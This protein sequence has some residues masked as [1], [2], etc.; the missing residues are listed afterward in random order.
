MRRRGAA[1]WARVFESCDVVAT[2]TTACPAPL[3]PPGAE[4]AGTLHLPTAA[5]LV[6]FTMPANI[7]GLPAISLPVGA[8]PAPGGALPVALQLIGPPWHEATLLRAAWHL[9]SGLAASGGGAPLA[10]LRTD[11]LAAAAA[12]KS[13]TAAS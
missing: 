3:L 11:P 12:A 6:R 5:K 8:A 7:L 10:A 4:S 9:G 2:P 13:G 1:H